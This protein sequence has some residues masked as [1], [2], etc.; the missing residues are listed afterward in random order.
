VSA[1]DS[2][3]ETLHLVAGRTCLD[4]VNT[5][6][7]RGD[8][9]RR[10]DHLVTFTDVLAWAVRAGVVSAEEA[11]GLGRTWERDPAAGERM[12][13]EVHDLRD[14]VAT[15]L[16]GARPPSV[17]PLAATLQ[18][19]VTH[20]RLVPTGDG[21]RWRVLEVDERTVPRRLALDLLDLLE[22]PHGRLGSCADQACG[23]VFLDTSKAGSRRWCRSADC[24]NRERVR[25]HYRQ[26]TERGRP[27]G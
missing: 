2:R 19:A 13:R 27:A 11:A 5:V 8:P 6:S 15:H 26:Q 23:W 1:A 16:V 12:L 21:H 20:S 14:L 18:D 25:R 24:G 22:H 3:I 4:L 7:W 9:G 17:D 10:E